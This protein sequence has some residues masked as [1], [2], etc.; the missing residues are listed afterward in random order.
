MGRVFSA[1]PSLKK[2]VKVN[3]EEAKLASLTQKERHVIRA[4]VEGSGAANKTLASRLF[5]NEHTFRK[6]L[7]CIYQKLGVA[8][9]LELYIYAIKHQLDVVPH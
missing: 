2:L 8:S 3:P 4:V 5:V 7:T 6:H 1:L 9:R